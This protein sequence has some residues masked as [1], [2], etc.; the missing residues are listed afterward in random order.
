MSRGKYSNR[1]WFAIRQG[2]SFSLSVDS[3][4]CFRKGRRWMSAWSRD[5]RVCPCFIDLI[6]RLSEDTETMPY[7]SLDDGSEENALLID[8]RAP[9]RFSI[10]FDMRQVSSPRN[11]PFEKRRRIPLVGSLFVYIPIPYPFAD[12]VIR[13]WHWTVYRQVCCY[14]L[15]DE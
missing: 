11:K 4:M 1:C 2:S 7:I 14:G 12:P 8:L 6:C 9:K 15:I 5:I 3:K 10:G 13:H